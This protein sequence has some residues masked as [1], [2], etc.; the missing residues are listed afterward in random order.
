MLYG[1]DIGGTKIEFAVFD[2]Q[3]TRIE[4]MRIKTPTECYSDLLAAIQRSVINADQMYRQPGTV[5]VGLPGIVDRCG[6]AY[7][8][9][10]PCLNDKHV[11]E[12]LK[13]ML[14]RDVNCVNDVRAFA[15]SEAHGGA[16]TG[17]RSM[18][19]VILGTGA[20]S[21]SC[22]EGRFQP[23]N[24][25]IAGEWGHVSIGATVV[26]RHKLPLFPC[27]CGSKGCI[28]Q[29]V[30]GPG[31]ARLHQHITGECSDTE[32]CVQRLRDGEPGA[33][34]TFGVWIDCVASAFAQLV[35]HLNPECIVI[36]GGMSKVPE[37]FE[38][39]P[40]SLESYLLPAV[41]LPAIRAASFGDDSGVRGAAIIGAQPPI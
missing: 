18:I 36:G 9:N 34:N 7:S 39:L 14:G 3:L 28:E 17:Y 27:R 11:C 32:T 40:A 6:A 4:S 12:D 37:I 24:D 2:A 16:A 20:A 23:D 38:A 30:A 25:G 29:Y 21:G 1:V 26:E 10:V 31:L 8:V 35:H 33:V 22:I 41:Q 13:R 5:G 19:G 15:L